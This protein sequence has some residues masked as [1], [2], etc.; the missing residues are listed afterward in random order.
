MT[1][2][3]QIKNVRAPF[4]PFLLERTLRRCLVGVAHFHVEWTWVPVVSFLPC[5]WEK[6]VWSPDL[7]LHILGEGSGRG[8]V[9]VL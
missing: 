1:R 7:S 2:P 9:S 8:T 4:R 5:T 3:Y 6:G